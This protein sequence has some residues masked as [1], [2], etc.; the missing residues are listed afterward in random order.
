MSEI[1]EPSTQ[2][3]K[4]TGLNDEQMDG[5]K[6][7]SSQNQNQELTEDTAQPNDHVQEGDMG[8]IELSEA[9][10]LANE[11]ASVKEK[12]L[13]LFAEFDNYKRRNAKERIELIKTAGQDIVRDLLPV[14]DDMDRFSKAHPEALDQND[15]INLIFHKLKRTLQQKGLVEMDAMHTSFDADAHEA[16]TEIPAPNDEL[17]G[18]VIDVVEKGYLLGDKIIRYAKVVVGK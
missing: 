11:L 6:E 5:S 15:G 18:K 8:E 14:I 4:V 9:E 13:R 17:K 3:P 7:K 1:L 10:K 16:I 2:E 12:Y